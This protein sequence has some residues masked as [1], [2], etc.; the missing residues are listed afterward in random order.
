MGAPQRI[1]KNKGAIARAFC[2]SNK[3]RVAYFLGSRMISRAN[4]LP[5]ISR[6]LARS[7]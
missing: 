5:I 6:Q 4:R 1:V 2:V 3:I 7:W